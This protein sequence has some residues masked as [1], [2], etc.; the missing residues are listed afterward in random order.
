[1]IEET[2]SK[3]DIYKGKVIDVQV[4]EVQFDGKRSKRELVFHKGAV[5]A[6]AITEEKKIVL[7]RQFRKAVEDYLLE[8]PAGKLEE[9]EE[10]EPAIIR[11]LREETGYEVKELD[12]V[13]KFYTSPGFSN[14]LGHLFT[15]KLGEKG[16]TNF[17]EDEYIEIFEMGLDEVL[18]LI[19]DGKIIDAKTILAI[20]MYKKSLS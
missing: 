17:D 18:A 15:A 10:I 14:E 8:I 13:T 6:V 7:V 16:D 19:E 4:Q 1:M 11:E 3:K 5:C 20:L 2:I 9:G 12:Y